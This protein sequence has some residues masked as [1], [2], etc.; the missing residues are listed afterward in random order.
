MMIATVKGVTHGYEGAV[1]SYIGS[2]M[3]FNWEQRTGIVRPTKDSAQK[4][5]DI[6]LDDFRRERD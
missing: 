6:M 2:D 4:D 1:Q 3:R 5:A